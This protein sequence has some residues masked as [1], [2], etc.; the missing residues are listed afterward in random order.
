[1]AKAKNA[2]LVSSDY[3]WQIE[4]DLRTLTRAREIQKDKGRMAAVR[5][6]A[7]E[8]IAALEAMGSAPAK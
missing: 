4:D 3:K 8:K 6:L 2:G 7:K 1:M 5:K